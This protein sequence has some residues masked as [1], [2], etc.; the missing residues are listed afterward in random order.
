MR[1]AAAGRLAAL[2][3]L[4]AALL[5]GAPPFAPVAAAW[6]GPVEWREVPATAEGRQW[7]DA[8]SLRIDRD[9]RLSVLS[10]FQPAPP[11]PAEVEER[12]RPPSATLYVM[13]LDCDQVLFRDVSIN[14]LPRFGA[15]WQAVANDEL[16]AAV[17]REACAAWAARPS[18]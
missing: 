16:G 17:I 3:G 13:Q 14:G 7:W 1:R 2:L 4:L 5:F 15:P 10:R 11:P 18:S 9:G 12:E 8:G 6:G